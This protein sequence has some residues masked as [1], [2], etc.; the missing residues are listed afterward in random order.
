MWHKVEI[1]VRNSSISERGIGQ[2]SQGQ[3]QFLSVFLSLVAII[4]WP[5]DLSFARQASNSLGQNSRFITKILTRQDLARGNYFCVEITSPYPRAKIACSLPHQTRL[6]PSTYPRLG[7]SLPEAD[8]SISLS[9]AWK[10][11]AWV[12]TAGFYQHLHEEGC[13][14]SFMWC[15]SEPVASSR[16]PL[17]KIRVF[18]NPVANQ[19][20]NFLC[21]SDY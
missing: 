5:N 19:A 17:P 9:R 21:R 3:V 2:N 8:S 16:S 12:E 14:T 1:S 20:A 4:L 13:N 15:D 18:V 10:W 6:C 11:I 7:S